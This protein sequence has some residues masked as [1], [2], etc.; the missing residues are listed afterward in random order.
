MRL[1][2]EKFYKTVRDF[3]D[4]YL[5]KHRGY[6]LNTQKS[7]REAINL[8]LL[9]FK[10]ER[11]LE[12]SNVGFED[13]TYS[14]ITGFLEWLS[15]SRGCSPATVNL[16]LMAIRSFTKY[17]GI[18]DSGKIYMQV[19]VGNISV[20][21]TPGKVVEFLTAP[22]LETL[23]EQPNRFKTNGYRDFCFMRLMY[24][25]AA[26]CQE[27]VDAKIHD[28]SIRKTHAT[29]CLTGKGNKLRIVPISPSVVELLKTYLDKV[30]PTEQRKSD[31]YLFFTT[32]HGRKSRMSTDAVNLFMK[33][34]GEM[35]KEVGGHGGMD[36]IMDSR[37]VYCLQNGLPLDMDVYDLA[38]WCCLAEL[39]EL[40]MDNGCAS[41]AFPDFTRGEWN[42]IKGYKHA[43]AT[44]EEEA[45]IMEKAK[46][47]TQKLKE[48]G[49]EEWAEDK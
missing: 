16:R 44:P 46:A 21:K 2:D 47:F 36:F 5:I 28:L 49:A 9:Y 33:K 24:D 23:F 18:L 1:K 38:E 13:I 40:S 34:Y 25:T 42:K 37:L 27:L 7:Y 26:R 22:A 31:D 8:L 30:H 6:S 48:K 14:N 15:K 3:L 43:Y 11:G 10:A 17:A 20:R 29:I 41:V 45:A 4:I 39:G 35:A 32:H 19:E 12:Y